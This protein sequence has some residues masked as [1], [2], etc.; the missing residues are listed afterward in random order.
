MTNTT[1]AP[2]KPRMYAF[3]YE[4]LYAMRVERRLSL[5]Q[6]ARKYGCDHTTVLNALRRLGIPVK[7]ALI[8]PELPEG[9]GWIT[10]REKRI[11]PVVN[12]TPSPK[13]AGDGIRI[14]G[15]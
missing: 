1:N 10:S 7:F 9:R 12:P 13:V 4:A 2:F 15:Q 14:E 11:S 3:T 8:E 6:I 5:T